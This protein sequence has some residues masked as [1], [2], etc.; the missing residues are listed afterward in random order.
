MTYDDFMEGFRLDIGKDVLSQNDVA[1][2]THWLNRA[3]KSA[4]KEVP[5]RMIWPFAAEKVEATLADYLTPLSTLNGSDVLTVWSTDPA[6]LWS[7][8]EYSGLNALGAQTEGTNLRVRAASATSAVVIYTRAAVPVFAVAGPNADEVPEQLAALVAAKV[9]VEMIRH[10]LLPAAEGT[11]EKQYKV[12]DDLQ[13][14]ALSAASATW[15][16]APWL[17]GDRWRQLTGG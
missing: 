12:V 5:D 8:G 3:V 16:S 4:L 9:H 17:S 10:N 6:V 13:Y 7:A 2:I 11:L 1:R 14:R 15:A